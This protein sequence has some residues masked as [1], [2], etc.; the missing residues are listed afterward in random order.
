MFFAHHLGPALFIYTCLMP[1]SPAASH[2][3]LVPWH[4]NAT[5]DEERRS[6]LQRRILTYVGVALVLFFTFSALSLSAHRIIPEL[7]PANAVLHTVV[8]LSE[9]VVLAVIWI[10][11]RR[12]P[13]RI[14]ALYAADAIIAGSVG[15]FLGALVYVAPDKP[16]NIYLP[17]VFVTLIVFFRVVTIPS[18]A[19]RS[20][21]VAGLN[22]LPLTASYWI[23]AMTSP[24]YFDVSPMTAGV[25]VTVLTA[26]V[27]Y[28]AMTGS[29]VIYDLRTQAQQ[30]MK[31]GQYTLGQKLGEGGMGSV[32]VANHALLRRPTA[33]KLLHAERAAAENLERFE[34]EVQL[35]SQLTHPNTIA[36]YDYGT[37]PDG[38]FYYVMEYLDGIDLDQ[39]VTRDGP[40]SV[41]RVVHILAQACSALAEAHHR[42]LIHRDIKPANIMICQRGDMPDVVKVFD[43][44]LVK[45]LHDEGDLTGAN[46]AGTPAYLCPETIKGRR[47][48]TQSDLYA[49]GATAYFLL[50]GRQVFEGKNV[51]ELCVHHMDTIP[52]PPSQ[53][54]NNLIPEELEKI[55]LQCLEKDPDARPGS[56]GDMRKA[57]LEVA[58]KHPWSEAL[59]TDWWTEFE[60]HQP[61]LDIPSR[62]DSS[63]VS[64][65]ITMANIDR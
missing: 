14:L 16:H 56:A 36:I 25:G 10:F 42:G 57:L 62:E 15:I 28:L 12:R 48:T 64:M 44:G 43:F 37:T 59:A 6:L 31:F 22:M 33:I 61:T 30:A 8:T 29:M 24:Q 17:F 40:Q 51:P 32:Y 11:V 52:V 26:A 18:R 55:V 34:R 13:R 38:V 5:G 7:R 47:V 53:R 45:E 60:G 49:L 19:Y 46:V 20:L 58:A 4:P 39:L 50:T 3:H 65:V 63:G 54:T 35:T 21:L 41:A 9:L 23:L 1:R 2:T 27:I